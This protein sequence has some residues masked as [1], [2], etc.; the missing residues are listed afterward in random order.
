MVPGT[1]CDGMRRFV[2]VYVGIFQFVS[3]CVGRFQFMSVCVHL[4]QSMSDFVVMCRYVS[5]FD[6][7]CQSVSVFVS[8]G[9]FRWIKMLRTKFSSLES[10]ELFLRSFKDFRQNFST[11]LPI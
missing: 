1:V 7:L 10:C 2:S 11:F 8:V 9:G 4:F 3:V 5:V 6:S